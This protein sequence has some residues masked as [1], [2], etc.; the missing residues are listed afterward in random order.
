MHSGGV[1]CARPKEI[2][3]AVRT[4]WG[5]RSPPPQ[6]SLQTYLVQP[7]GWIGIVLQ[8]SMVAL[9][10]AAALL[11]APPRIRFQVILSEEALDHVQE[12]RRGR[13]EVPITAR[14]RLEPALY[15]RDSRVAHVVEDRW[16]SR[17]GALIYRLKKAQE[18][19]I[20][21][22]ERAGLDHATIQHV[23]SRQQVV[24]PLRL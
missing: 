17:S 18:L 16:R 19:A 4:A 24:V 5:L 11:K 3:T 7:G 1:Y 10:S 15:G 22:A 2:R 14:M 9:L 13:C 21:L 8:Y 20:P 12:G 6:V 23:K